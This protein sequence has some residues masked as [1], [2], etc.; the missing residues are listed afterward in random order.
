MEDLSH[1][2]SNTEVSCRKVMN[3]NINFE[4]P[5]YNSLTHHIKEPTLKK[6]IDRLTENYKPE[7]TDS[8]V[9]MKILLKDQI[10]FFQNPLR[11]SV[12]HTATA[13]NIIESW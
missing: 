7:A 1:E 10:L 11:L 8:G 5:E 2:H 12:D 4:G 3:L 13:N 6:K 9:K